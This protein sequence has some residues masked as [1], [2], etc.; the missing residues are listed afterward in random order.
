M[1]HQIAGRRLSRTSS[2]RKALFRN[3]ATSLF[4]NERIKTTVPKAK[5]LRGVAEKLITIA[6][7]DTLSARRQVRK[8]VQRRDVFCKLFDDIAP[9][10]KERPGGYTRIIRVGNRAGDNAEMAIIELVEIRV[11]AIEADEK[12]DKKKAKPAKKVEKEKKTVEKK[13]KAPAAKKTATK[14]ATANKV[15]AKPKTTKTKSAK[16]KTS[17]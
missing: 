11:A 15:T 12:K 4:E 1:R 10:F 6:R 2:H 17:K 14:T 13:A 8:T 5:E 7:K 16:G 9:R 3:L